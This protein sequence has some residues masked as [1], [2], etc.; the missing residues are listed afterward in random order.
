MDLLICVVD[1]YE[2]HVL[3]PSEALARARHQDWLDRYPLIASRHHDVDGRVPK[4]TFAYPWD[5]YDEWEF[6][7]LCAMCE[8]GY[9]EVE[10][11][12]H[13]KNDTE[14][15]LT[16][17]IHQAVALY[18][19]HGAFSHWPD[20]NPAYAFVH[21]DWALDNSRSEHGRNYCGVNSEITILKQTGCYADFTFP[22]WQ[23]SAQP[24]T[25]NA[26]YYATDNPQ[27]P[28]SH[29]KGRRARV[30]ASDL[31]DLLLI[32]GPLAPFIDRSRGVTR[33][34]MD[35]GDL[36]HSR[37]YTPDR[38]DR[39]VRTGITV[40]GRPDR[41]FIKLHCHGANDVNRMDLLGSD[42][43]ALYADAEARY[44]DGNLF[45]AHYLTAREMYNIVK[46]TEAAV[47]GPIEALRD[48]VLP[49]PNYRICRQS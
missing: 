21:G 18:K 8:Q 17:K 38:L 20:G 5:E 39:W 24:R 13:H 49:P 48:Y 3:H 47:P 31:G 27:H 11:H 12:L 43:D 15:S 23:N 16:D 10:L 45:R 42:L 22:A 7:T 46:A 28:K 1:H 25:V 33:V 32:Q 44:N 29:D 14:R 9:G 30:G 4:H 26:I 36:A 41:I 34:A 19:S 2:P 37:R 35:D 6:S 40:E